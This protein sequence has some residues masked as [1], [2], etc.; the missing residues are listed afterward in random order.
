LLR[1]VVAA[2]VEP[3]TAVRQASL[4]PARHYGLRDRGAVAPGYRADLVVADDL[5]DFRISLVIKDGVV[6]SRDGRFVAELPAHAPACANT[7]RLPPLDESAFEL[8]PTAATV[9]VIR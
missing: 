1:R 7:I 8:R 4:V 9:P 5:K 2:G 6:A 3:A